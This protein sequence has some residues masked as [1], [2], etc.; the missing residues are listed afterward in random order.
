MVGREEQSPGEWW[1]EVS[2]LKQEAWLIG[3][4]VSGLSEVSAVRQVDRLAGDPTM[5][6]EAE[7]P[8]TRKFWC[9]QSMRGESST[10][11][12]GV[13]NSEAEGEITLIGITRN[14]NTESN[15][16]RSGSSRDAYQCSWLNNLAMTGFGR[17]GFLYWSCIAR[18]H[19]QRFYIL[20]SIP[21]S[22]F[23]FF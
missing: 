23:T 1:P 17:P 12:A 10:S 2:I 19:G 7:C 20:E 11:W 16:L 22:F 9:W 13:R 3:C 4:Q 6:G 8:E 18:S 15:S 14:H 5:M 21:T